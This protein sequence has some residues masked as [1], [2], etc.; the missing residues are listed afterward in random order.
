[1]GTLKFKRTQDFLSILIVLEKSKNLTINHKKKNFFTASLFHLITNPQ[2]SPVLSICEELKNKNHNSAIPLRSSPL[3]SSTSINAFKQNSLLAL[4]CSY[5]LEEDSSPDSEKLFSFC[6][7]DSGC[8]DSGHSTA[9]SPN[10]FKSLSPTNINPASPFPA[11]FGGI[12]Y[13]ELFLLFC[14]C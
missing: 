4:Q 14:N 6:D 2:H 8:A 9:H 10:D 13:S 5:L 1:V 3:T 11:P 7:V 12:P